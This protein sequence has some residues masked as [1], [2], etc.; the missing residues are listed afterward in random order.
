MEVSKIYKQ[1]N[2]LAVI[3]PKSIAES[4]QLQPGNHLAWKV[5]DDKVIIYKLEKA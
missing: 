1:G 2:S 5:L 4:L 3:V